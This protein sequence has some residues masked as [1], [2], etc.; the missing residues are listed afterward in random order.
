MPGLSGLLRSLERVLDGSPWNSGDNLGLGAARD[1]VRVAVADPEVLCEC[2]E[3]ELQLLRSKSDGPN[4]VPFLHVPSIRAGLAFGYWAPSA[5]TGPHEHTAWTI[6]A[7][8]RNKLDVWVYDWAMS[9]D[10]GTLVESRIVNAVSPDVGYIC[11]PTIHDVRNSTSS[12][13]LALHVLSDHDGQ[14]P[15]GYPKSI[16]ADLSEAPGDDPYRSVNSARMR[17]AKAVQMA[18]ILRGPAANPATVDEWL[19]EFI[20]GATSARVS[21]LLRPGQ[22][23]DAPLRRLRRIHPDLRLSVDQT[24]PRVRLWAYSGDAAHPQIDVTAEFADPLSFIA[25]QLEF[26]V[27][28]LPGNLTI[29]ER[30]AFAR[31]LEDSCLFEPLE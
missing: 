7:V 31:A 24:G 22:A 25:E 10:C 16:L 6:T 14:R 15:A 2:A 5:A 17:R 19:E 18:K 1:L 12:W 20:G 9:Y 29:S 28:S 11:S 26:D 27:E 3:L 23:P 8:I 30:Q 21:T 13:S 4:L